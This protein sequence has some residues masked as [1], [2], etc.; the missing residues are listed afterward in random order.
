MNEYPSISVTAADVS[1]YSAT[2]YACEIVLEIASV[3]PPVDGVPLDLNLSMYVG[4]AGPNRTSPPPTITPES[5]PHHTLVN[6]VVEEVNAGAP[7][8]FLLVILEE[9]KRAAIEAVTKFESRGV[10]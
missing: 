4:I 5:A 1:Q 2:M 8:D 3:R 7:G 6:Y 10:L 9:V